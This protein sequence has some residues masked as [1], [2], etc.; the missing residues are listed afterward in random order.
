MRLLLDTCSFLWLVLEP[1]RLSARA[2]EHF[3][4]NSNACYL[5]VVSAW[6]IGMLVDLGRLSLNKP[7]HE[8]VPEQRT[9][10]GIA[11][12]L[13]DEQAALYTPRLPKHHRD[14][15]DRMLVSQAIVNGLA[16]LTPDRLIGR[17]PVATI[18]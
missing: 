14:P 13:L 12:L 17:Y 10:H 6:E 2:V 16:I 7:V 9:Q 3:Q 18:W 1:Q 8:Y 4:D 5:S 15:F 11:L